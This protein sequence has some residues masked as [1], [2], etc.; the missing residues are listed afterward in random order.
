MLI[1]AY[2]F[3]VAVFAT[4]Q[5]ASGVLSGFLPSETFV[6]DLRIPAP[7]FLGGSPPTA[8][9]SATKDNA[10]KDS[11]GQKMQRMHHVN[12]IA[13]ALSCACSSYLVECR[14]V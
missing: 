10:D 14:V 12:S 11:Q 8:A 7:R 9:V 13:F 5:T 3:I 2:I 6:V 4:A 1:S